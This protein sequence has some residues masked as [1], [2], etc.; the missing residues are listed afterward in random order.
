MKIPMISKYSMGIVAA[1]TL[2]AL[3]L[4]VSAKTVAPSSSIDTFRLAVQA[5]AGADLSTAS[6]QAVKVARRIRRTF[7]GLQRG[8]WRTFRNRHGGRS[9]NRIFTNVH[10]RSGRFRSSRRIRNRHGSFR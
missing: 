8:G 7:R 4:V 3:P 10:S 1:L 9:T 5:P 6:D 2:A